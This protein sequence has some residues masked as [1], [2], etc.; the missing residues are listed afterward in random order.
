METTSNL[1]EYHLIRSISL[2]VRQWCED[3]D[4]LEKHPT[5]NLGGWCAICSA[6]LW[7]EL[8]RKGIQAVIG[9]TQK[10]WYSHCYVVVD[11]HVI[12]VT[13]SQFKQFRDVSIVILHE[14]EAAIY[15]FYNTTQT[16]SDARALR[17]WQ[18][19]NRWPS[20]QVCYE[21]YL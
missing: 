20:E 10:Q 17:K 5:N 1:A 13:A 12:D 4:Q 16:F 3:R 2:Q 15:E 8:Q 19:K 7:R 6:H 9:I 11:D 14:R 18:K 21:E